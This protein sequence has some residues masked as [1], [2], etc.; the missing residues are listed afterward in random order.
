MQQGKAFSS[1]LGIY[2][3]LKHRILYFLYLIPQAL[4]K[5]VPSSASRHKG[6][7]KVPHDA[8][9]FSTWI[10]VI[11]PRST[12]EELLSF[13][14]ESGELCSLKM[15]GFNPAGDSLCLDG[16]PHSNSGLEQRR[17]FLEVKQQSMTSCASER[18]FNPRF[19]FFSVVFM[20]KV[21]PLK[22]GS[23]GFT[24]FT[25]LSGFLGLTRFVGVFFGVFR[26]A[27]L[28]SS[29]ASLDVWLDLVLSSLLLKEQTKYICTNNTVPIITFQFQF[30]WIL[31]WM[32]KEIDVQLKLITV[33]DNN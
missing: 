13:S 20:C 8:H 22:L 4:H 9:S 18:F 12:S 10:G 23:H 5:C 7:L 32:H 15:E 25:G 30:E 16:L 2:Q 19:P 1:F 6:V 29:N 24:L 14:K 31:L 17:F 11:I 26:N 33:I 27:D 28:L 21:T 3:H